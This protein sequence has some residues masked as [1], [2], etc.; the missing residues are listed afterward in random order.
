MLAGQA[1]GGLLYLHVL[2]LWNEVLFGKSPHPLLDHVIQPLEPQLTDVV[3]YHVYFLP[4]YPGMHKIDCVDLQGSGHD[5]APFA[6]L[7]DSVS[8]VTGVALIIHSSD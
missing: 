1:I 3:S 8:D 5:Q 7:H 4:A 6:K 2:D